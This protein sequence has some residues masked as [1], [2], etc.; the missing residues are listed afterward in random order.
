[1]DD[2]RVRRESILGLKV[3]RVTLSCV[4][5]RELARFGIKSFR[6]RGK[7]MPTLCPHSDIFEFS[8]VRQEM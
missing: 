3:C 1:M 7:F 8:P 6:V 4:M 2:K 5:V